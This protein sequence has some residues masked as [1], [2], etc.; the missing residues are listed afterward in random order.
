[1]PSPLVKS[2]VRDK[3]GIVWAATDD[4]LVRFD[5]REF[6]LFQDELPGL[7]AKS[8]ICLADGEMLVTTDMGISRF[9]E[10]T[11]NTSFETIGRGGLH[12]SD[13]LMWFPKMIF[14]DQQGRVWLSD[15]SKVYQY[16][17]GKFRS[18]YL[19]SSVATNN[20]NRSFSFTGDGLGN[21]FAFAEPGFVF[22]YEEGKDKLLPV[23][24]PAPITGIH[25]VFNISRGIIL[26]ATAGGLYEMK[27]GKNNTVV[28]LR[29]VSKK[30]I[31]Y[32]ASN[33]K[34]FVFAG[35]WAEGLFILTAAQNGTY[36]FN[37]VT[38][39][40][41]K[42]VNHLFIDKEDNIWASS[43][44]G[45]L[46]LQETLFGSPYADLTTAYIQDISMAGSGDIYFTD[47][48]QVFKYAPGS[49]GLPQRI[50][51][52]ETAILQVVPVRDGLWISDAEGR[53][54][55]SNS[56]GLRL[57]TFDFSHKGKA[58][59]KLLVDHAGNVW[60]CQD[61]NNEII[62]I[63]ADF[64]VQFY[65]PE[66]GLVSRPISLGISADGK[67]YCG[68]MTD[69]AYLFEYNP[70]NDRFEN[71]SKQI[72]FERNIDLNINDIE[73][74]PDGSLWLGSSFGLISYRDGVFNR[75]DLGKLT[76][77]SV[78]AVAIDSLGYIWFA[79][80]KGLYRYLN[81]DLMLFDERNGL[82]SKNI[83]YRGLLVDGNNRMWA[84]TLAGMA[85]S[86]K[87]VKPRNTLKPVVRSFIVNNLPQTF[88]PA[89]LEVINNKSF[90]SLKV[91]SPE[92]PAKQLS[93]EHFVEGEDSVWM[94]VSNDGI[95]LIGDF[96]PG[97]YKLKVRAR[98]TGNYTYSEPFIWNFE[99]TRIWYEKWW[100]IA[101]LLIVP[102]LIL[103]LVILWNSRRLRS[104][105]EKLE[106]LISERTQEIVLQSDHIEE[107]NAR[108]IRKNE[109]LSLKNEELELAKNLAEEATKAKSQFLS[110]M[111]HEIRTPMN[112]VIGVT[113]LL[114]RDNPRPDQ[115]EDLKIL[116]FSA[117]NLLGLINDILDLNKIEAG[118]LVIESIDFNLKSLAE[119]VRSSMLHKASE[120]GIFIDFSYDENLPLFFLS[121]PL[122]I[123]QILN[124]LLSN[125]IKFTKTGGVTMRIRH[126]GMVDSSV[127]V[128]FSVSDTGIGIPEEMHERIFGEF[129]QA[130]SETSRKY[131]GTGLGLAIT[132]KLLEMF[133]S[134]IQ[135][136]S[137]PGKG[138]LFSFVIHLKEGLVNRN[139]ASSPLPE[140]EDQHFNGQRILLVEDNKIN[141][142]IARKFMEDW[143]LKVDSAGNGLEAIEK[144]NQ[145][146]FHLILMD[147]QMPEM[148]G[149]MTASI[150]RG[151]GHEPFIS[152]PIIALTASSKSEVQEK[153][154]LAGMNDFVSKPFNPDELFGKLKLYLDV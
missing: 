103:R 35:T 139:T 98:Q 143:N 81:G 135:L 79:N 60:A 100:V 39:Y 131:G 24:L 91:A 4:G 119:G 145:G 27:T 36:L 148:D 123:S 92:Y 51:H 30:D 67:I 77:N 68:G 6:R 18:Y 152:I 84:G 43:D 105:N 115:L 153:I 101:L 97:E 87:L 102:I 144:L 57:K 128:A 26:V 63:S 20:F 111:S 71:L 25:A 41:E 114:M 10:S 70:Q 48:S 76:G 130:S 151:R 3:Q 62:R 12:Q 138:S 141:E 38:Q 52:S 107:Q 69:S 80:N 31:S 65:G 85:V 104:D 28:S 127:A 50:F 5:G 23:H 96:A 74:A 9:S 64:D 149:Y 33:S 61:A 140:K 45:I 49:S 86:G 37:A 124:N 14:T 8:V 78:K 122:R 7:Y 136:E 154:V 15:N 40:T 110:V 1:L 129:T 17:E 29:L 46:L 126:N 112:A 83:A 109:A 95:I 54:G 32:M 137:E 55:Y 47:G 2:I 21:F 150:I 73:C 72:D 22:R 125:A 134:T 53:I 19:G 89:V 117:E 42:V 90:I 133:G 116:K 82:P 66:K 88:N 142:L 106:Q 113:H 120:K 147:L 11:G 16:I 121:D 99:V 118:K 146:N 132:G 34:G 58:I 75:A 59:F 44:I 56:K 93:Y 13:T 108:I 94:P